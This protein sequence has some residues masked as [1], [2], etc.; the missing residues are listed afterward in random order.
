MNESKR[1]SEMRRMLLG[2][3]SETRT[4]E[5]TSSLAGDPR[6]TAILTE[7][8]AEQLA[9]SDAGSAPRIATH[10]IS[11][12]HGLIPAP[13]LDLAMAAS[14][15]A[16]NRVLAETFAGDGLETLV[17]IENRE[18]VVIV[19]EGQAPVRNAKVSLRLVSSGGRSDLRSEGR[20]DASGRVS[21][22]HA[23]FILPPKTPGF[24]QVSVIAPPRSSAK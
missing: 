19:E 14:S 24:Y 8:A 20:T 15:S 12:L 1:I 5:L 22:G 2:Q 18:I 17:R 3:L 23:E 7:A 16:D 11:R 10:T 13:A 4:A 21:L 9:D 6:L